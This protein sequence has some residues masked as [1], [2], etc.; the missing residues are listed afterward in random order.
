MELL[1]QPTAPLEE[2]QALFS[3]IA[4]NKTNPFPGKINHGHF[5]AN[6]H[7]I[8]QGSRTLWE[9]EARIQVRITTLGT[10]AQKSTESQNIPDFIHEFSSF[11]AFLLPEQVFGLLTFGDP[12]MGGLHPALEPAPALWKSLLVLPFPVDRVLHLPLSSHSSSPKAR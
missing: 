12:A 7:K 2:I 11:G 5:R 10:V 1:T 9:A 3:L 6:H 8:C 4:S